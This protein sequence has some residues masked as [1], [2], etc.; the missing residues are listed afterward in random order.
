MKN[1]KN[2]DPNF[3]VK[4]HL[5]EIDEGI[6]GPEGYDNSDSDDDAGYDDD[7]TGFEFTRG[8]PMS[9]TRESEEESNR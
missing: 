9:A 4:L 6:A 7:R 2:F 3:F 5:T 1:K 8:S